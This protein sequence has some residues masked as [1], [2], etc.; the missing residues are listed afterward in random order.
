[1]RVLY[2]LAEAKLLSISSLVI[3]S[4]LS[5]ILPVYEAYPLC[6]YPEQLQFAYPCTVMRAHL[7]NVKSSIFAVELRRRDDD[8]RLL[9]SVDDL[10]SQSDH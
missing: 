5:N 2:L 4:S 10:V 3:L 7:G 6:H 9:D 8:Y 1:V